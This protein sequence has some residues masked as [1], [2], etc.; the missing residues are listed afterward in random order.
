ME[1]AFCRRRRMDRTKGKVAIVTG[2][3]RGLGKTG[4]LTLAREGAD[5]ALWDIVMEGAEQAAKE[6]R[7]L[8]SKSLA[9]QVDVAISRAVDR[10]VR[11]TLDAF[12]KIDILVNNAGIVSTQETILDLSNRRWSEEIAV[13]LTGTFYCMKAVLKHMIDRRSGKIVNISSIAGETGRPYTSAAYSAAKAGILG[14]T[15]SVARSVAQYGINVN[16]VCP[17]P[18][19]T[20]IHGAYTSEQL[21]AIQAG[22]PLN[23]GGIEGERGRPQ[24]IADVVLFLASNESN[25]ITGTRIRVNGGGLMG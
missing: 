15:M 3:G 10:A 1:N 14:L 6:A 21:E 18:I 16:A 2:A 7:Q 23:R 4:A 11:R 17:G 8:G 12:G 9:I 19:I 25:Y 5:V 22:I 13:N 20:E 24:D